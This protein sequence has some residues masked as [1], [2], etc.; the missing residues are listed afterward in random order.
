MCL[1]AAVGAQSAEFLAMV[2]LVCAAILLVLHRTAQRHDET[3]EL[4][5]LVPTG[6]ADPQRLALL[7]GG[8]EGLAALLAFDLVRRGFLCTA[9]ADPG[10]PARIGLPTGGPGRELLTPIERSVVATVAAATCTP[11][12]LLTRMSAAPDWTAL[13]IRQEQ[14]LVEAG[15]LRDP[16]RSPAWS[17]YGPLA[18]AAILGVSALG[19]AGTAEGGFAGTVP[20]MLVMLGSL[21]VLRRVAR[22]SPRT[23]RGDR[24]LRDLRAEFA[25][26]TARCADCDGRSADPHRAFCYAIFGP[27]GLG[28]PSAGDSADSR[29]AVSRS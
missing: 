19:W 22:L 16:R 26:L 1:M 21:A 9:P 6:D 12:E 3:S 11:A 29:S 5:P 2:V 18:A 15:L 14:T 4:P 28:A 20:L 25:G 8:R 10:Q 27:E 24:Y 7:R 23:V 13:V 17:P